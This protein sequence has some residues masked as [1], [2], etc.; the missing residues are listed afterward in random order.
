MLLRPI[1]L[2]W[3]K[4]YIIKFV[5]SDRDG[6][7]YGRYTKIDKCLVHCLKGEGIIVQYTMS[8]KCLTH[9]NK[10]M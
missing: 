3:R 7:Y 9:H 5:R 4:K 8:N 10:I 1:K 6:E 2:R